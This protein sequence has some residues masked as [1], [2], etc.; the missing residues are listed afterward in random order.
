MEQKTLK[1]VD[2]PLTG[3]NSYKFYSYIMYL[4]LQYWIRFLKNLSEM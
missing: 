3:G 4:K 2:V 1:I